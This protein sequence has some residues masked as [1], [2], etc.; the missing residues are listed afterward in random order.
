MANAPAAHASV[1]NRVAASAKVS[2]K[3]DIARR[4]ALV[5]DVKTGSWAEL[6]S[7]SAQDLIVE[8][9]GK[10]IDNVDALKRELDRIAAS[11]EKLVVI[12]VLRGIHT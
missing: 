11:K 10:P 9:N 8:V 12:K 3:M 1:A 7:L 4:C 2:R 5:E 6:G